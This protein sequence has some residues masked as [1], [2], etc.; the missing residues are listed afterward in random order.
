M[1]HRQTWVALGVSSLATAMFVAVACTTPQGAVPAASPSHQRLTIPH[2][3]MGGVNGDTDDSQDGGPSP[4]D[5][6]PDHGAERTIF[7]V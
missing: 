1:I 6:P 3:S 4:A 2:G 7:Y 5:A